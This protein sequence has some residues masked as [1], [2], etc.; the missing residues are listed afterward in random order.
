MIIV[1]VIL[2]LYTHSSKMLVI[3]KNNGN[4]EH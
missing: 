1:I 4:S 2:V 3:F